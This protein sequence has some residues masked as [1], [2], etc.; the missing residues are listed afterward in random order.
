VRKTSAALAA[1]SLAVLALTGCTAAPTSGAGACDRPDGSTDL[2]DAVSVD[3]EI[4]G[5]TDVDL[6]T[7]LKAPTSS[8]ADLVVGDGR[9]VT[10]DGQAMLLQLAIYDGST[11]EKIYDEPFDEATTAPITIRQW[12][13]RVPGLA[14]ALECVTEGSRVVAA[15]SA[16]DFGAQNAQAF[17]IDDDG[18]AV[19]VVDVV[20]VFLSQAEGALRFNDARNMPTVVRAP[21]GTPG[22]IIPDVDAPT[23]QTVQTLIEGDGE[24]LSADQKPLVNFT[25]VGWDDKKVLRT[26]WGDAPIL[27]LDQMAPPIAEALVGHT[28]G[29]Q[30]LVVVPQTDGSPAMAF[31]VDILGAVT[32]PT[33]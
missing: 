31:V 9:A 11:G 18:S 21:D 28:V 14:P 24:E 23:S 17:G 6:F 25:A 30:V 8:V 29:S 20:D 22:V 26:T 33:S 32:V 13:D 27:T 7:P 1:L 10:G 3:G 4:G 12:A 16:E 19:F 2:R 15:L 5:R